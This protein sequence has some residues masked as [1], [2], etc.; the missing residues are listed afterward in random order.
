MMSH[1]SKGE[2]VVTLMYPMQ[3]HVYDGVPES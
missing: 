1:A 2:H 3:E